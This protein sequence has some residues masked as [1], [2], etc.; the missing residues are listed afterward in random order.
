MSTLLI[1]DTSYSNGVTYNVV[2]YNNS[3]ATSNVCLCSCSIYE[4][5]TFAEFYERI[6][7]PLKVNKK[8]L[9][10][11]IRKLTCANDNRP[12][13]ARVGYVGVIT[14]LSVILTLVA[15]DFSSLA[16]KLITHFRQY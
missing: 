6:I 2:T 15:L 13:A 4:N 1:E 11:T 16:H 5:E 10:S 7:E 9:S 14:L 3:K 12:S 8:S